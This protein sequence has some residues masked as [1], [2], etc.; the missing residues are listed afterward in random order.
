MNLPANI[1]ASGKA[2]VQSLWSDTATVTRE[3]DNEEEQTTEPQKVYENIVCHLVQKNAPTLDTSEAAALTEPVF[4]LE[5]DT[6]VILHGGDA[7]TVQH[8]GQT[9]KGLAGKP[10]HRTFCNAVPLSG[11]DIA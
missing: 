8:N 5:V 7:V 3:V 6:A 4:T 2:A 1:V 10:F 11:V 9:L